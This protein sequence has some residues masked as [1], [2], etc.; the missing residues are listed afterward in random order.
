MPAPNHPQSSSAASGTSATAD[1]SGDAVL[2]AGS[3]GEPSDVAMTSGPGADV[4]EPANS[5]KAS[6]CSAGT[7]ANAKALKTVLMTIPDSTK[8][9]LQGE[10]YVLQIIRD[11][12]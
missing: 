6:T 5:S 1:V 11:L 2:Q 7:I 10:Q 8:S 3:A 4:N 12:R 9:F